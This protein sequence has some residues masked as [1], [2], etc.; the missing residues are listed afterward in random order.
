MRTGIN[1]WNQSGGRANPKRRAAVKTSVWHVIT[2][3][4]AARLKDLQSMNR[5]LKHLIELLERK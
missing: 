3:E 4:R 1:I 5:V 2:A